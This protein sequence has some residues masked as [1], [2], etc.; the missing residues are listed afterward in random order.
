MKNDIAAIKNTMEGLKSRVEEAEDRISELEDKPPGGDRLPSSVGLSQQV[1]GIEVHYATTLYSAASK[2]NKLEQVEKELMRV[3]QILKESK[4]TKPQRAGAE[5]EAAEV[6]DR[7]SE[8]DHGGMVEQVSG[9]CQAKAGAS[10]GLIALLTVTSS[11]GGGEWGYRSAP[12]AP[13]SLSGGRALINR[14]T[15]GN[16]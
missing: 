12:S 6:L 3:A 14:P 4:M 8:R 13:G 9:Q 1:Y 16:Q 5:A 2:Q 11:S 10:G 15:D 7:G